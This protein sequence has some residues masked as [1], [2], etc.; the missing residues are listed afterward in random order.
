MD[1]SSQLSERAKSLIAVVVGAAIYAL[2][3]LLMTSPERSIRLIVAF[4]L[5]W[6]MIPV[7]LMYDPN[8]PQL[9]LLTIVLAAIGGVV[10]WIVFRLWDKKDQLRPAIVGFFVVNSISFLAVFSISLQTID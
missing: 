6:G 9:A 7:L 4:L 1:T 8:T 5:G 2:L 3:G 10:G